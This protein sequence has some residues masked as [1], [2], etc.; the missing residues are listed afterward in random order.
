MPFQP[1]LSYMFL[2]MQR[3]ASFQGLR[4]NSLVDPLHHQVAANSTFGRKRVLPDLSYIK[5]LWKNIHM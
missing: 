1:G 4:Q 3:G 5:A 2:G